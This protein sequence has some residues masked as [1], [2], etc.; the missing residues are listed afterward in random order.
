MSKF[1]IKA[2]HIPS[3]EEFEI[4]SGDLNTYLKN[5]YINPYAGSCKIYLWDNKYFYISHEDW[6]KVFKDV[7][8]GMPKYLTDKLDC[9][10]FSILVSAR[11]SE[12]YKLNTCG[13]AIGDGPTGRH[14]F[15]IFLSDV[16]LFYMEPQSGEVY[17]VDENSGYRAD[18][19]IFA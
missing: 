17:S 6:G 8:F 14:G 15:N 1:I 11:V 16:G 2:E 13:I 10:N 18:L 9:E 19:V 4:S 3:L 5:P 12:R 7:L